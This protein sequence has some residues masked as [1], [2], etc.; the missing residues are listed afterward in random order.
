LLFDVSSQSHNHMQILWN[1]VPHH[2]VLNLRMCVWNSNSTQPFKLAR[3]LVGQARIICKQGIHGNVYKLLVCCLTEEKTVA[4]FIKAVVL[5]QSSIIW[6]TSRW[7]YLHIYN[8]VPAT[9]H[10]YP[11]FSHIWNYMLNNVL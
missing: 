3:V 1:H 6:R 4:L 11:L 2:Y 7:R 5:N 8:I 10:V 9:V